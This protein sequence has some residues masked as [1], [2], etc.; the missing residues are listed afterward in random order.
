MQ[1]LHLNLKLK[2]DDF[3]EFRFYWD[4]PLKFQPVSRSRGE[5]SDLIKKSEAEYYTYLPVDY[6]QTGQNLYKWLNGDKR[7]LDRVI[8]DGSS[9]KLI[10]LAIATSEGLSHLPWELLHDGKDFLVKSTPVIVPVRWVSNSRSMKVLTM[11]DKPKNEALS[12]AFMPASPPHKKSKLDLVEEEISI[13]KASQESPFSLEIEYSGCLNKLKG[14]INEHDE[15]FFDVLHLAGHA[16]NPYFITETESG[17]AKYSSAEDIADALL[18]KNP[19]LIFLSACRTAYSRESSIPS[20]AESLV[21]N[22]FKAVLGWGDR[23]LDTSAIAA[24]E[25]FYQNLS[26]GSTVTQALAQTYRKLIETEKGWHLLRLYVKES[27]PG[28]LVT[29]S[30]TLGRIPPHRKITTPPVKNCYYQLKQCVSILKQVKQD[31]K[32]GVLILG[33]S[34]ITSSYT[35]ALCE[36]LPKSK[37]VKLDQQIDEYEFVNKLASE[38][39]NSEQRNALSN[40]FQRGDK[41]KYSLRDLFKKRNETGLEPLFFLFNDFQYNLEGEQDKLTIYAIDI[42]E[43]LMGAITDTETGSRER[44]IITSEQDL[45]N[46]LLKD[47]DKQILDSQ[48]YFRNEKS[49]LE[50]NSSQEDIGQSS[51]DLQNIIWG[52]ILIDGTLTADDRIQYEDKVFTVEQ[53]VNLLNGHLGTNFRFKIVERGSVKITLE[54]SQE[55]FNLLHKFFKDGNFSDTLGIT[56]E[57]LIIDIPK[58]Q[59]QKQVKEPVENNNLTVDNNS[60]QDLGV[61]AT[62]TGRKLEALEN[63]KRRIESQIARLEEL[64]EK[65][66]QEIIAETDTVRRFQLYQKLDNDSEEI[67]KLSEKLEKIECEIKKIKIT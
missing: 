24:A 65:R 5:I 59:Q 67:Y 8:H 63:Q 4:N 9:G 43:N 15:G 53:Y 47:F 33:K 55:D 42:L 64:S 58:K 13:L 23:V 27:L 7:D 2:G 1:I 14:L 18:F 57:S 51:S 25:I 16:E 26:S 29:A 3:V 37:I 54:G 62:T 40:A 48:A 28:A 46:S 20:M 49:F 32:K 52:Q 17:E 44:V 39:E 35:D 60:P 45:K 50:E 31:S 38:L 22:G 10:V 56:I 61:Q 34:T 36:R 21:K 12:V 6:T 66:N 30:G 41:L 19:Q 11:E